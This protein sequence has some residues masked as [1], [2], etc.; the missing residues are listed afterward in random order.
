[1]SYAIWNVSSYYVIDDVV[2]EGTSLYR[3]IADARALF[4]LPSLD[5][6]HW[7]PLSSTSGNTFPSGKHTCI[8]GT[9]Q[10]IT[11]PNLTTNGI[12]NLTYVHPP[13]GGAGQYFVNVVPTANTLTITLGQTATITESIFWSVAQL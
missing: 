2:V 7:A 10:T 9:T 13:G 6:T 8:V 11:I 5:A 1:M 4:T 12:V 3:C